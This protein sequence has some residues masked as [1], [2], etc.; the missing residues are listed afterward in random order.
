MSAPTEADSA[1][2]TRQAIVTAFAPAVSIPR[3]TPTFSGLSRSAHIAP[4]TVDVAASQAT[5]VRLLT[6][7]SGEP[8]SLFGTQAMMPNPYPRPSCAAAAPA[9]TPIAVVIEDA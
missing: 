1:T 6:Q 8:R 7:M 4:T 2:T 3:L 5:Q 9:A